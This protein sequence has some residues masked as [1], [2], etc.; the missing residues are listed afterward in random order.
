MNNSNNYYVATNPLFYESK[1]LGPV[2]YT[3]KARKFSLPSNVSADGMFFTIKADQYEDEI[4]FYLDGKGFSIQRRPPHKSR[5]AIMA[6][7]SL[8]PRDVADRSQP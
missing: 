4:V 3:N 6:V 1:D 8:S 5:E 7:K 2:E